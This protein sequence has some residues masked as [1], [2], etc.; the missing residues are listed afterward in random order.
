MAKKKLKV[1]PRPKR[2]NEL[3]LH[4]FLQGAH[5]TNEFIAVLRRNSERVLKVYPELG[6]AFTQMEDA[7]M[8][9]YLAVGQRRFEK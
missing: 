9:P 2:V 8:D 4:E 5:L 7:A 1:I 3:V 6:A